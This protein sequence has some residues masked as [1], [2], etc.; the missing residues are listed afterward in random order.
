MDDLAAKLRNRI[1]GGRFR[2][3]A[4]AQRRLDERHLLLSDI[5]GS[6]KSWSIVEIYETGRMGPS[7]LARHALPGGPIHAVWV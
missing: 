7:L 5:L 4:H 2:V 1:E 3:S 6:V